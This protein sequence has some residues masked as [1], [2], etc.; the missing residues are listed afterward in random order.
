MTTEGAVPASGTVLDAI[1][2]SLL[3]AARFN[4]NDQVRPTVILWTDHDR[5]WQP[6]VTRLQDRLPQLLV[7]GDYAPE[8]RTGPAIWLRCVIARKLSEPQFPADVVPI[9]YLPGISR[10]ELRAVEDCAKKLQPLAELQYRGVFWTQASAKDW[11]ICAFLKSR[12]GGLGLDVTRDHATKDALCRAL[13][14]LVEEPVERLRTHRID[15]GFL[16][17]LLTPDPVRDLLE[18]LNDPEE[19]R[20]RW[21]VAKWSAFRSGCRQTYSIDPQGEGALAAAE[22]LGQ[23]DGPWQAVWDRFAEGPTLNGTYLREKLS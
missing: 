22:K 4:P 2:A 7:L 6:L 23:Q 8:K 18:W 19:T 14:R 20:Q 17:G 11:T 9:L 10:Q 16:N 5:L 12:H 3:H 13:N 21:E 15:A 1:L